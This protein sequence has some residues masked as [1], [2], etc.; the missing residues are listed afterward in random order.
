MKIGKRILAV[1]LSLLLLAGAGFV[2]GAAEVRADTPRVTGLTID[3][4]ILSWDEYPGA[5]SYYIGWTTGPSAGTLMEECVSNSINLQEALDARG[6][7]CYSGDYQFYVFAVTTAGMVNDSMSDYSSVYTYVSNN[8]MI[9]TPEPVVTDYMARWSLSEHTQAYYITLEYLDGGTWT[10][11][12]FEYEGHTQNAYFQQNPNLPEYYIGLFTRPGKTYRVGVRINANG[13]G[14]L[15]SYVGYSEPFSGPVSAPVWPITNLSASSEGVLTWDPVYLPGIPAPQYHINA[16][17][18][19]SGY[20]YG[21]DTT[22]CSYDLGGKLTQERAPEGQYKVDV[23]VIFNYGTIASTLYWT[24]AET[25][26][27]Y[28]SPIVALATPSAS[29]D[30]QT[31]TW[32]PVEHAGYYSVQVQYHTYSNPDWFTYADK[33]NVPASVTSLE[34]GDLFYAGTENPA[35]FAEGQYYK[36]QVEANPLPSET[37]LYSK[38]A[39]GTSGELHIPFSTSLSITPSS[40]TLLEGETVQIV[41]TVTGEPGIDETVSYA[42]SN[43]SVATV[44]D[45]GLVTAVARGT[46]R[47]TVTAGTADERVEKTCTVKVRKVLDHMD[48][49]N[50]WTTLSPVQ[51]IAYTTAFDPDGVLDEMVSF[52]DQWWTDTADPYT[53]IHIGQD[54]L[55]VIGHTYRF[56]VTVAPKTGYAFTDEKFTEFIYGGNVLAPSSYTKTLNP[57]GSVTLDWGLTAV[58]EPDDLSDPVLETKISG[59]SNET[60][61]G[62]EFEPE[63]TVTIK[64][65]GET[66]TLTQGTDYTVGWENNVNAGTAYV[67]VTGKGNFKGTVKK[68]F[69][70]NKVSVKTL[71]ISGIVDKRYTG[72]AVTQSP[73]VC[74][75]GMVLK[76][77]TDYTLSYSN[78]TKVGSATVKITGKG[79]FKDTY[80]KTFKITSAAGWERLTGASGT[81]AL[82]T[83]AKITGKFA[84]ADYAV[85]A[86][87]ADFKDA[88][89]GVALA[90]AC[91]APVFMNPKSSL[92]P[93]VKSEL[94]RLGV[95]YVLVVGSKSDISDK[96]L[97]DIR[98]AINAENPADVWRVT[99]EA[100]VSASDKSTD[101]GAN[102]MMASNALH[103]G[104]YSNTVIIATQKSFK[105]ALSVSPYS[106]ATSS[107]IVYVEKDLTLS[108]N[109][110]YFIDFFGFTQAVIVGGPVAIPD[111][112]KTQLTKNTNVTKFCRLGGAGCYNT[113]RIIAEWEMGKLKNGTNASTG[114][115]YKYVQVQFQPAVKLGINNVGI[116]R[117]DGWKDAIAGSALCGMNRAVLL[118]ADGTNQANVAVVKT[119]KK[120][121][122]KG[123]VFGGT[124]AVPA[125]VYNQFVAAAK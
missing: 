119:Y 42:S 89:A 96:V 22:D 7:V 122:A 103:S 39:W 90:G 58:S 49:G 31:L 26:Y 117:G 52:Q 105:D 4:D 23:Q 3:G 5:V 98:T 36:F 44:S 91:S 61:D 69:T 70:I 106:Y 24:K 77:G 74:F 9:P 62:G 12:T 84:K 8:E 64:A 57:D 66:R 79:N 72:K 108:E 81:G 87:N 35:S 34:I 40:A 6:G 113:S 115:L 1:L 56:A 100:S 123:Y 101:A 28:V 93:L 118:L 94:V 120:N 18:T 48:I 15:D 51:G 85:I 68:A 99:G 33:Y 92:S 53:E 19:V 114:S 60:Y 37:D 55:P 121:I 10:Q 112:V 125:K 16:S 65:L 107:P 95:K 45:T 46:A 110:L 73:V 17:N 124:Q 111:A 71:A 83:Q 47:I 2:P 67:V 63:P 76:N 29:W 11:E 97:Q 86:T 82:G 32:L 25:T 20:G 116:S 59:I 54:T 75:D 50:V 104:S 27:N 78:N 80:S 13:S 88:L 109:S 102:A 14:Y 30:G 43:P 38:S 41:P 21:G